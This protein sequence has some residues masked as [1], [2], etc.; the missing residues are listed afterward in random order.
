MFLNNVTR[1]K[2][3]LFLNNG[4]PTTFNPQYTTYAQTIANCLRKA[5]CDVDL[6]VIR[7][8]RKMTLLYK[9]IKYIIY[10]FR[11]LFV[12]LKNYD[13]VYVNHLPFV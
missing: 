5:G 3:V 1:M 13:V 12:N 9:L 6:L 4:Y 8:N 2:K 7:Y 11:A 10:W